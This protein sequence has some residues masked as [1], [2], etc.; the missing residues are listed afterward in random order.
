VPQFAGAHPV[1]GPTRVAA[2][3][4]K[5]TW[6]EAIDDQTGSESEQFV[7]HIRNFLEC[8]KSRETPIASLSEAHR[9]STLCHLANLSLRS[10]TRIVWD[11]EKEEIVDGGATNAFLARSYRAPWAAELKALG[12]RS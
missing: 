1:G 10:K 12:I 7:G 3:M 9:V 2:P 5:E 6:T 4:M 8:I 11:A